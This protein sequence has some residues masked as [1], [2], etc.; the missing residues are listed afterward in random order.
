M[1]NGYYG[2]TSESSDS[3]APIDDGSSV[4]TMD[5]NYLLLDGDTIQKHLDD[6]CERSRP[7]GIDTMLLNH[8]A[9]LSLPP[10]INRFQHLRVLDISNNRLTHVP[11]FVARLPLTTLVAKNNLIDDD[12][13]PKEF[14]CAAHLKV[15]N[16]SG[17]RLSHFPQQLL[18]VTTL[19]YLYMGSNNLV[20]IPKD[21]NKLIR[22]KFLCLGGNHLSDV[23]VT[24]GMLD[25]L[26]ALN[27]SD[28]SLESLPPAIANLKHLKSLM[29]HKNRLRTLPVEII[30]LKCLTE[31]SLRDNPLVVRFVSDMTHNPPSLLELSARSVKINHVRYG[32]RDLPYNLIE[33]LS[34]AHH[35]VNPK[36]KGVFFDDRV[37]H[38]K[39][40][41]FC[42]KYRIPLLQYLCSSKCIVNHRN[43]LGD[44]TD[45]N[46]MRKVLL[47]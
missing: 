31:L 13:F 36:C 10:A 7:D 44:S 39:F 34:S 35:C 12:G 5:L 23:P 28:N 17:N 43:I 2:S 45:S 30:S 11:N 19:E 18:S 42:G 24:L 15:L 14:G 3:D 47:G 37:E 1:F 27:L 6:M 40:V 20:E 46:M 16:I 26:K 32:E 41:D 9:M 38:I 33:Y 29:L 4:K 8:N 25:N 21:I 22:L